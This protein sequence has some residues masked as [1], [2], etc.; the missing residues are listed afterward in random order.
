MGPKSR[1]Q[2]APVRNEPNLAG[3]RSDLPAGPAHP[4]HTA[5]A[6]LLVGR[7][8]CFPPGAGC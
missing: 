2:G 1:K 7:A 6:G 3:G 8:S 5:F 4:A